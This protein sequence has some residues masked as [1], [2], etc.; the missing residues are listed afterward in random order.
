MIRRARR[1]SKSDMPPTIKM[2]SLTPGASLREQ[3]L[4]TRYTEVDRVE[5]RL[6][7][8]ITVSALL[9]G[10]ALA[11][12]TTVSG[13]DVEFAARQNVLWWGENGTLRPNSLRQNGGQIGYI[14][15]SEDSSVFSEED[16]T[17][18]LYITARSMYIASVVSINLSITI[19]LEL[20]VLSVCTILFYLISSDSIV[21]SPRSFLPVWKSRTNIVLHV[22]YLTSLIAS[23]FFF[24]LVQ[25]V[26]ETKFPYCATNVNKQPLD[27]GPEGIT[28]FHHTDCGIWAGMTTFFVVPSVLFGVLT[29][30]HAYWCYQHGDLCMTLEEESTSRSA[31]KKNINDIE[32]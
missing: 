8:L 25:R 7:I 18:E 19:S 29:V 22:C 32:S 14:L 28:S 10:F 24:Y 31:S 15:H 9:A 13:T 17:D 3:F 4:V 11:A 5:S 21:A 6:T 12:A 23:I 27:R 30:L 16:L 2:N 26:M 20:S 1:S